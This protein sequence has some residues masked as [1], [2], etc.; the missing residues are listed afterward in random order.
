MLSRLLQSKAAA[1]AAARRTFVQNTFPRT[2]AQYTLASAAA[3]EHEYADPR[4]VFAGEGDLEALSSSAA[5]L[6][7]THKIHAAHDGERLVVH[8][9]VGSKS[10]WVFRRRCFSHLRANCN[11]TTLAW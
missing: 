11:L 2:G 5:A 3:A 4:V 10:A 7:R 6:L 9:W 8:T 1:S